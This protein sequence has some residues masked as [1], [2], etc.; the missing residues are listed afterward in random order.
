MNM[1]IKGFLAGMMIGIAALLNCCVGGGVVGAFLFTIGLLTICI[2]GF[3][4]FTGNVGNYYF[5]SISNSDMIMMFLTNAVGVA[6]IGL[7]RC[8]GNDE[9]FLAIYEFAAKVVA[10][11]ESRAWAQTILVSI[12]CG[13]LV[14]IAVSNYKLNKDA[15]GVILPTAAFVILGFNHCIA[16]IFYY[17][18]AGSWRDVPILL[19]TVIGNW[20]GA[21]CAAFAI[22]SN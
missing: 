4:L 18:L 9:S 3:K 12:G 5:S 17:L 22:E 11:R 7:L 2:Q 21:M 19:L 6:F 16:D 14:Q 10:I 8:L 15:F 20:I 1:I 13:F